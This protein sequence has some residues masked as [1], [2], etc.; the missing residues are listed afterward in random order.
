[1]NCLVEIIHFSTHN[2]LRDPG[3]KSEI[4]FEVL[5]L[6]SLIGLTVSLHSILSKIPRNN[7]GD[8]ATKCF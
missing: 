4:L 1:M 6:L 7:T 3:D 8:C 2:M 5:F